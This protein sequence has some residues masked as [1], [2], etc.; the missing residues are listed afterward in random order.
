MPRITDPALLASLET[1]QT[2]INKGAGAAMPGGPQLTG[3][4]RNT[5]L[6][7]I[8]ALRALA[9]QLQVSSHEFDRTQNGRGIAQS[10]SEFAPSLFSPDNAKFDATIDSMTPLAKAA[11]RVPGSGA[12]SDKESAA[13]LS[14]VPSRYGND[15]GNIEKYRQM[16]NIIQGSV[17]DQRRLLGIK[18]PGGPMRRPKASAPAPSARAQVIDFNDLKD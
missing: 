6:Q 13:F 5:A 2:A 12:D 8:A 7:K 11:F 16:A 10:I 1:P 15:A 3:D 14:L 18:V 4:A 9:R 17:A